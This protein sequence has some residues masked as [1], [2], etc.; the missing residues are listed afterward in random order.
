MKTCENVKVD[1]MTIHKFLYHETPS[2]STWTITEGGWRVAMFYIDDEDLWYGWFPHQ[3]ADKLV[4]S[5]SYDE[6]TK[7]G[8]INY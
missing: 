1:N 3:H 7:Q 8:V 4:E 2:Y 5:Y 6:K